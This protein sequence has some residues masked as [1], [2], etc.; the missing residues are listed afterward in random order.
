MGLRL[1]RPLPKGYRVVEERTLLF[2]GSTMYSYSWKVQRLWLR[3]FWVTEY[4]T[5]YKER[6]E[7]FLEGV[8][9]KKLKTATRV[10]K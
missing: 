8:D 2:E 6:L 9:R 5:N 1:K 3:W 4:H 10:I 7:M